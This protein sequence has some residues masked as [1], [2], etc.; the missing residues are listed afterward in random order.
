VKGRSSSMASP[1]IPKEG[2][3]L[4]GPLFNEPMLVETVRPGGTAVWTV[5][6][7]GSKTHQFRRVQLSANDLGLLRIVETARSF[8]GDPTLLKLAIQ[9]YTLGIAYEFDP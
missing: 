8:D 5:G 1:Q 9:A 2:Q 4:V 6:L 7:V 3:F